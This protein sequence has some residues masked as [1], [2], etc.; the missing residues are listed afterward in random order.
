MGRKSAIP[1]M[2]LVGI[3]ITTE[4]LGIS[5]N[6]FRKVRLDPDFPKPVIVGKQEYYRKA[7]IHKFIKIKKG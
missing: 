7:D 2:N 5:Y 3:M 4:M 6:T 1:E